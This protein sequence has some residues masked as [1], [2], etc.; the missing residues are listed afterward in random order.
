MKNLTRIFVV[1]GIAALLF[2]ASPVKAEDQAAAGK[3]KDAAQC[4]E[5][6]KCCGKE[7]G[8][9][10]GKD[11]KMD[12]IMD[13]IG[14]TDEQ[15]KQLKEMRETQKETGKEIFKSIREKR[16]AIR[17]ELNKPETDENKINALIEEET[18]LSKAKAQH[19]VQGVLAMKKI[20]T[21]EQFQLLDKKFQEMKGKHH[22][23]RKH[24]EGHAKA[25]EAPEV[26]KQ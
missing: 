24:A 5:N 25:K 18:A 4:A 10:C 8:M 12:K 20:L 15:K 19:M 2:G 6:K 22:K 16:D 1:T 26:N 23:G 17:E 11:K 9:W 3:G 7:G 13:E 14:V 21:P